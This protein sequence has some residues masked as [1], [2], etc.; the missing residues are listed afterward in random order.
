MV[1]ANTDDAA[2]SG[3]GDVPT[4]PGFP[5]LTNV[6]IAEVDELGHELPLGDRQRVAVARVLVVRGVG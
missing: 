6:D 1:H 2:R 5:D 3:G 4:P